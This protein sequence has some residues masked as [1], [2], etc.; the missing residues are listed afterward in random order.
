M[1]LFHVAQDWSRWF[2]MHLHM[3]AF[4]IFFFER[5]KF[6]KTVKKIKLNK[7]Y[8]L[9]TDKFKYAFLIFGFLYAT[10]FH[11]H[12]FFHEGVRLELTYIK[13]LKKIIK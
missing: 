5:R 2:S 7:S 1:P 4:L 9:L 10:T 11:H 3:K 8:A 12:H 13:V 6:I